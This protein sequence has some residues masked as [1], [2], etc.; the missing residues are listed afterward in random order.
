MKKK[1]NPYPIWLT[2]PS[3]FFSAAFYLFPIVLGIGLAFTSWS[4]HN[5]EMKF[6]GLE[7]FRSVLKDPD[8]FVSVQHTLRYAIRAASAGRDL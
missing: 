1:Y 3:I 2:F 8:F 6:I 5:L 7:N 4:F